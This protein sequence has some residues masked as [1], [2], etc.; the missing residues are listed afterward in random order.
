MNWIPDKTIRG[1]L[2]THSGIPGSQDLKTMIS[3]STNH[4][5][6]LTS[7][8]L[9]ARNT[10]LN[11]IGRI[12]PLVVAVF[13][14]PILIKGLGMERFG[15]LTLA[16]MLIGYFSLFDL[17]IGRALTKLVAEKLG[18]GEDEKVPT[19]VWTSLFLM[20]LLG[21]LG[22]MLVGLLVPWLVYRILKIPENLRAESLHAFYLLALSI[23]LVISAAGL[24]GILEARQLFGL[25]NYVRIPLGLF[26]YIGPVVALWFTHDLVVI[27]AVL[28]IARLLAWQIFLWLC[29]R[30]LPP[31]R[32]KLV[33]DRREMGPILRFGGWLTVSNVVSPFLEYLDRF[34]IGALVSMTAVTYYVTP[35]DVVTKLLHF[36][37]ALVGVL[38]PAFAASYVTNSEHTRQLFLRG[39][40]LVIVILF[41]VSLFLVSMAPETL[42]IWLGRDFSQ[43]SALVL[44]LLTIGVFLNSLAYLPAT[45]IQGVG[46]PDLIAKL[47]LIELPFYL[48]MLWGLIHSYGITGAALAWVLRAGI[49]II[50]LFI[51]SRRFLYN[52]GQ[53]L[54]RMTYFLGATIILLSF[55]TLPSSFAVSAGLFLFTLF[56]FALSAWF[57][58]L[59][60]EDRAMAKDYWSRR[61]VSV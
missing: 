13:A 3:S 8:R 42:E 21:I 53:V 5:L 23:P 33:I 32:R 19:L 9:L 14:I 38:F 44:Q 15:V 41:P 51:I 36:P 4:D 47:H 27:V 30:A 28:A 59:S 43:Q 17:G 58:M 22:A 60:P 34:L 16:W 1:G 24:R 49:D 54:Q 57:F 12:S 20:L 26:T 46:R 31:L 48:I 45:L 39:I 35:Y 40:K 11:L 10:F 56:A 29:L 7:G 37:S 25:I 18:T 55:A 52:T 50:L 61:F 2:S 6:Q